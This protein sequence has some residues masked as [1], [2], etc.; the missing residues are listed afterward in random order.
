MSEN[1]FLTLN[2]LVVGATLL[3]ISLYVIFLTRRRFME[4]FLHRA[5]QEERPNFLQRMILKIFG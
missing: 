4:G 5:R 2:I 1:W 3:I